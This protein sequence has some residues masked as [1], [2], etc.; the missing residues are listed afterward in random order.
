[1]FSYLSTPSLARQ[2]P[3]AF[4]L[5]FPGISDISL[6]T[7]RRRESAALGG[8]MGFFRSAVSQ[9]TWQRNGHRAAAGITSCP[10]PRR[11]CPKVT[12]PCIRKITNLSGSSAK[13]SHPEH[14]QC[15]L[16]NKLQ[17]HCCAHL[18]VTRRWLCVGVSKC[19]SNHINF[20]FIILLL[21]LH[22]ICFICV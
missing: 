4:A 15:F 12:L 18:C 22:T 7:C 8:I 16:C 14:H 1:M 21:F 3:K 2:W 11:A 19:F 9:L 10:G 6:K 17:N 13:S 20:P 5:S